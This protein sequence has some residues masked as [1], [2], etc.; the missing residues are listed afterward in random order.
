MPWATA[1]GNI[2][3]PLRLSRAPRRMRRR[4]IADAALRAGLLP[5]DLGKYPS[6]L[7]G[8]MRQ[9]AAIARALVTAPQVLLLDEP[10]GAVDELTRRQLAQDLPPLWQAQG[11]TALLVTH[12]LA[13][14]VWL[15][16]RILVLSPRPARITADIAV[17]LPRPRRPG[18]ADSP[19]FRRIEAEARAALSA[20]ASACP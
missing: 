6:E 20:P 8:G 18:L 3:F 9:R 17:P 7:S 10:F 14:A 19:A 11:T 5:E 13:E 15:A 2:G 4:V 12:S 1:A 16:D